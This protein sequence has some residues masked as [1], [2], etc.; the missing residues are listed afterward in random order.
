MVERAAAPRIEPEPEQAVTTRP[1][2]GRG[3]SSPSGR[4]SRRRGY[5]QEVEDA[6]RAAASKTRSSG[7]ASVR[8]TR[9]RERNAVASSR[10]IPPGP[11]AAWPSRGSG[12]RAAA[13]RGRQVGAGHVGHDH[14]DD[15][16]R[17]RR[18]GRRSRS[19]CWRAAS[20]S[21]AGRA[22]RVHIA[23]MPIATAGTS[24]SPGSPAAA[25]PPAAPMN[26]GGE[27]R[28]AAEARERQRVGERPCRA[29]AAAA[30]RPTSPRRRRP[31]ARARPGRRTA[32][33]TRRDRWPRRTRSR[34]RRSA[35]P[36]TGMS[37]T[38][39]RSTCGRTAS[40]SSWIPRPMTRRHQAEGDRPAEHRQGRLLELRQ[41]RAAPARTCRS[42]CSA[43]S[44]TKIS[45]PMPAASS[46]GTQHHAE[47]R[48]RR[49]RRS[50]G[51]GTR[52]AS[53]EPSSELIAA[54]LPA[55]AITAVARSRRV[56]EARR[57][58]SAP[59]PLPIRISGASG[60]ST[61]PRLS[62]A[63]EASTTPGSSRG[64]ERRRPP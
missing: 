62:V 32:R 51:A 29:R 55:A 58:A 20:R 31:A 4:P 13:G 25:M 16:Q 35:T 48:R 59:R 63:R 3:R 46:P 40:A 45:V 28:P 42:R 33:S 39:R 10:V 50:R 56:A 5:E 18:R 24:S 7:P 22:S 43:S 44:P 36:S 26:I 57:I 61:A 49:A 64:R 23:P 47:H 54:K 12:S 34:E 21:A 41:A 8:R 17:H 38:I 53:G 6:E 11:P 19:G 14:R 9:P 37:R 27:H 15:H 52:R 60:P 2:R 1:R 30:R